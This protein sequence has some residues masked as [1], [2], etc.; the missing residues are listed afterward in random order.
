MCFNWYG[1]IR[2]TKLN[3]SSHVKQLSEI[4][5]LYQVEKSEHKVLT[6]WVIEWHLMEEKWT[7]IKQI[8]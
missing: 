7:E 8:C 4:D 6:V 3:Y 1:K 2:D 5:D